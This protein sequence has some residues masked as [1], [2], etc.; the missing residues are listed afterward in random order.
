MQGACAALLHVVGQPELPRGPGHLALT[1]AL[2]HC[3]ALQTQR[4][5]LRTTRLGCSSPLR[6][7]PLCTCFQRKSVC[8]GVRH[9][10]NLCLSWVLPVRDGL[11]EGLTDDL[12]LDLVRMYV[13]PVFGS[14]QEC[15]FLIGWADDLSL[16]LVCIQIPSRSGN[17]QE[18]YSR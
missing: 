11:V 13:C 15:L 2:L 12:L 18:Y 16:L 14:R 1:R 10:A 9:L 4:A 7:A 3:R 6:W 5:G 17:G 8:P